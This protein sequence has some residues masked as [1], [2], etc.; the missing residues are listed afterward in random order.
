VGISEHRILALDLV[1]PVVHQ[2]RDNVAGGKRRIDKDL[3][4]ID[5]TTPGFALCFDFNA[6]LNAI[7]DDVVGHFAPLQDA[8]CGVTA[9][10]PFSE[11]VILSRAGVPGNGR[12][13]RCWGG[14]AKDL[15]FA[16]AE[17]KQILRTRKIGATSR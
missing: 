17:I 2:H 14:G 7:D 10:K 3:L 15:M 16:R 12:F 1:S 6:M 4:A 11:G 8:R 5:V 13:C 9:E